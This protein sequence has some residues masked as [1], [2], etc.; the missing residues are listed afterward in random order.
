MQLILAHDVLLNSSADFK[1]IIKVFM[2]LTKYE[3]NREQ[4]YT[5]E[6]C[7]NLELQK[8]C[9]GEDQLAWLLLITME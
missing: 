9:E 8:S 1:E 7:G 5:N 2:K 4:S 6:L 3:N